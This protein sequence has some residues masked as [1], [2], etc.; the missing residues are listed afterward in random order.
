MVLSVHRGVCH[1]STW[2]RPRPLPLQFF[3]VHCTQSYFQLAIMNSYNRYKFKLGRASSGESR[4]VVS[5][6]LRSVSMETDGI[7]TAGVEQVLASLV[8]RR[9]RPVFLGLHGELGLILNVSMTSRFVPIPSFEL[10]Y[11]AVFWP[12]RCDPC[13]WRNG[14]CATV[15]DSSWLAAFFVHSGC[16]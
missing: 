2:S 13:S 15:R 11:Q 10:V 12:F 7:S 3:P 6:W 5:W 8:V 14:I 4:E 16:C 1:D 9:T